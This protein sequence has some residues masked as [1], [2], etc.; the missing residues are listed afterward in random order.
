MPICSQSKVL[1]G[2]HN[3]IRSRNSAYFGQ[4]P[5][6]TTEGKRGARTEK[7][8]TS[9][10]QTSGQVRKAEEGVAHSQSS[11]VFLSRAPSAP[12]SL[13][14]SPLFLPL[15]KKQLIKKRFQKRFSKRLC[16][17]AN[18]FWL[19]EA[20]RDEEDEDNDDAIM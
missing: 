7:K 8:K 3:P 13:S 10:R 5:R 6:K 12:S 14:F 9:G 15:A 17:H 20:G 11:F 2:H 18:V 4:S 1:I 19:H 16:F